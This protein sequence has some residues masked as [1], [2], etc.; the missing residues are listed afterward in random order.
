MCVR[1][2]QC[3]IVTV[4]VRVC[5]CVSHWCVCVCVSLVCV[6]VGVGGGVGGSSVYNVWVTIHVHSSPY[7]PTAA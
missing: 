7:H 5:D 1:A 6:C 2:C 3:V 4:C